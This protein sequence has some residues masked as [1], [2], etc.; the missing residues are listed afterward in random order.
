MKRLEI[1]SFMLKLRKKNSQRQLKVSEHLKRS[2]ADIMKSYT[3]NNPVIPF[4]LVISEVNISID[5][6]IAYVFVNPFWLSQ[7]RLEDDEV[8]KILVKE[9]PNIRKRLCSY[10]AL[11]FTPKIIFK[12]D[13][14]LQ[15]SQKIENL[16]RD[17]KIAQDLK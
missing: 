6:K 4:N 13:N 11:R 3:F 12:I 10:I 15:E 7:K 2:L 9:V 16:F 5:L 14:I 8:I 17:P 1:V